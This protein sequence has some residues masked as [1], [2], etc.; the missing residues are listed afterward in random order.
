MLIDRYN[1]LTEDTVEAFAEAH[2]VMPYPRLVY[3]HD[4]V[5]RAANG[6]IEGD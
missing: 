6:L 5:A 2:A 3:L 1:V 4:I